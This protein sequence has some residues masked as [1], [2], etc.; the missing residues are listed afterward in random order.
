MATLDSLVG[1]HCVAAWKEG[2]ITAEDPLAQFCTNI[3]VSIQKE[4]N[5]WQQFAQD[6]IDSE[7]SGDEG[8]QEDEDEDEEEA[9]VKQGRIALG[10]RKAFMH[11]SVLE[12]DHNDT[13]RC[14]P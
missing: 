1:L 14:I 3:W 8:E 4:V 6:D 5:K 12:E 10:Q 7:G 13:S 11:M 9:D 2:Q